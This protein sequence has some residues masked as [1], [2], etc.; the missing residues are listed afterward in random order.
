MQQYPSSL[1]EVKSHFDQW[2]ATRTKREKIPASLWDKVKLLIGCY[3][4]TSITK[5]LRINSNQMKENLD[6]DAAINF[7]EALGARESETKFWYN[8][9]H[10]GGKVNDTCQQ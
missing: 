8:E 9:V 4:L 1:E 2:R 10:E 6:M 3:S 7:V 5:A